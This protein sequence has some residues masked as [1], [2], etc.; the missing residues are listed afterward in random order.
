M[1]DLN[2]RTLLQGGAALTLASTLPPSEANAAVV[3][4]R[5]VGTMALNDPILVSYRKAVAAMKALPANDP[6]NWQKQSDIHLNN[7]PHG[8]WFFLPWHRAYLVAF[9]RLCRQLS[10]DSNFALPYWD[11][12]ANPQLPAAFAAP[13]YNG[14]N[15]PLFDGTRPSQTVTISPTYTGPA[16]ISALYAET[17]FEVFGSTRPNNQNNISP[18]WQ[19]V[20]GVKGPF[21]SGPHDH[22]HTTVLGDML[23]LWSPLDPVFWLHH[24]NIDRIWD[25]WNSLGRANTNDPLWRTYAF[26]GQFVNPAGGSGTTPYNTTV[27]GVLDIVS[28]GYRYTL[29]IFNVF[30]PALVNKFINPGDPVESIKLGTTATAKINVATTVRA[31]LGAPQALALRKSI[32]NFDRLTA[33][34]TANRPAQPPGRVIV[35]IRN[36]EEPMDSNADVRVFINLPDANPETS[37]ED[38]HYA[39][40]FTFFGAGHG[41][42]GGYPSYMIDITQTVGELNLAG[43]DLAKEIS[44]QLVPVP[45]RGVKEAAELKIGGVEVAIF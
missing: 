20:K 6:R 25:H 34:A 40:S 12:T 41:A 21:E 22:V 33:T 1:I 13:T 42:H 17:S 36:V 29:P 32:A 9:E 37:I 3:L 19:R 31:Q 39:G 26:N 4:R 27:A 11:W 14:Q 5:N 16:V 30:V 7:C 28:L 38:R 2:R 45:V 43:V 35:F 24:C 8:N 15:N 18:T 10:G 44:V 23:Q